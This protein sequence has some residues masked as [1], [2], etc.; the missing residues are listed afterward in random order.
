MKQNTP[1]LVFQQ[2]DVKCQRIYLQGGLAS[3][4]AHLHSSCCE[5]MRSQEQACTP[6][7][8][9]K[10]LERA[11]IMMRLAVVYSLSE[12]TAHE[13]F[14]WC[15]VSGVVNTAWKVWDSMQARVFLLAM[16]Y[17]LWAKIHVLA[18]CPTLSTRC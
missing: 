13:G 8:L 2:P 16:A 7:D 18:C 6:E 9:A 10:K 17:Y 15:N 3:I 1:G 4:T 11:L 5:T 12:D 14:Q